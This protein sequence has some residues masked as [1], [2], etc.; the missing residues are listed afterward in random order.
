MIFGLRRGADVSARAEGNVGVR[1]CSSVKAAVNQSPPILVRFVIERGHSP[2]IC[3]GDRLV[4]GAEMQGVNYTALDQHSRSE[5]PH[6]VE[7][8]WP[9]VGYPGLPWKVQ[10]Q[11]SAFAPSE[12][13]EINHLCFTA[14]FL[15]AAVDASAF[16]T[17]LPEPVELSI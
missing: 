14:V 6:V 2:E 7:L 17:D 3:R 15:R 12:M 13:S 9:S 4:R 16:E 5:F 8:V 11:N 1:E 10:T